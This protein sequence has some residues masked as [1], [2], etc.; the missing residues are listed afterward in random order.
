MTAYDVLNNLARRRDK[1]NKELQEEGIKAIREIMKDFFKQFPEVKELRWEQF[2]PYFND[3]DV[4]EFQLY[5]LIF[6]GYSNDFD[7]KD[8]ES[9]DEWEYYESFWNG[10]EA[11]NWLRPESGP[12]PRL[13]QVHDAIRDIQNILYEF[14]DVLEQAFGSHARVSVTPENI[15]VEEYVDHD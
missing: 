6:F 2:I 1:F 11:Y 9:Y 8:D 14:E 15:T 7:P 3:G 10:K 12:D 4:C 5:D 13:K